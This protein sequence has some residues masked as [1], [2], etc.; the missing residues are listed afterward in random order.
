MKLYLAVFPCYT[1]HMSKLIRLLKQHNILIY[2]D[3]ILR[4]GET[5]HYY[6]DIKQGLGNPAILKCIVS[7]LVKLIP[8]KTTCIAGSGYGGITLASLV[9]YKLGLPLSLVRDKI[10]DHGT[11]K[12]IDGYVPT[13]SDTTCIID[14]VFTTGSSIADTR[15]KLINT[16]TKFAKPVVVL[17]R[18]SNNQVISVLRDR[19]LH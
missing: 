2:G 7:E 3:F 6:C 9:A 18:S 10:K 17:N 15:E 11:K 12:L 4:S 5:S 19:D 14:D 16:G 1:T 13:K 8:V